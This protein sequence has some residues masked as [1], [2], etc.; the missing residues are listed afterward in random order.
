M[1]T[2]TNPAEMGTVSSRSLLARGLTGQDRVREFLERAVNQG[3][4][5]HAYLFCGAPGSGKLDAAY[6]LAQAIV[7]PKGGC[8]V[9]DDCI[10]VSHRTHPDVHLLQPESAQ[11][12][13]ISQIRSL[14]EDLPLAPIRA[15]RKVY[16]IDEAEALRP[17]TANALLKSLEEPPEGITFILLGTSREAILATIVSRCQ[18]VPFRTISPEAALEALCAEVTVPRSLC[19]RAIWCC[20]SP[21]QAREFV[22]SQERQ[23]ARHQALRALDILPTA[24]GLD[25]L[26]AAVNVVSAA[27]AP[28]A[29]LKEEHKAAR[30]ESAS[31]MTSGALKQLEDRQKRELSARE[32]S[33]IMEVFGAQRSLLRDALMLAAGTGEEPAC[34]DFVQTARR[35]AAAL[36]ESGLTRAIRQV[37]RASD[38]VRANVSPQLAIEAMLFNIKEMFTCQS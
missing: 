1:S 2:I 22:Q 15:Q 34:D 14:I 28:Y 32:R 8:G 36:G 35:Y 3:R 30:D 5:S 12:Y 29:A 23:A 21:A 24:D 38:R 18:V 16:I 17:N 9:C 31:W 26:Q 37:D 19:R 11:G 27:K 20:S 7:C 10:R 4:V 33:G 13:L 25:V 6:A